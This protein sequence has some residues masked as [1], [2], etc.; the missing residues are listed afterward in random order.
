VDI[1]DLIVMAENWL[2]IKIN[3]TLGAQIC[4]FLRHL[5]VYLLRALTN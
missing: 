1:N 5:C 4:G 3:C 2:V